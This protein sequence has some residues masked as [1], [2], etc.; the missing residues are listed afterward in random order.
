MFTVPEIISTPRLILRRPK[1]SDANAIFEFGRDSEVT[2]FMDWPMHTSIQDAKAYLLDCAPRWEN[3]SEFDWMITFGS[4]DVIGGISARL[5]RHSADFGYI[6][7]RT[8]W[9][10]GIATE[11]ANAVV[12]WL[13]GLDFVFRVWATC[14]TEN[15]ASVRVLEKLGFEREGILRCWAVRPNICNTPRD[16]FMYSKIRKSS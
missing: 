1:I 5:R 12:D 3:S 13:F 14:D 11:A 16:A 9:G 6:L 10:Q 4:D 15:L 2:R 8:Y 7:N